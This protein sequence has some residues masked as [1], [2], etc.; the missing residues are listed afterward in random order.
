MGPISLGR[1]PQVPKPL[2]DSLQNFNYQPFS[3]EVAVNPRFLVTS[4]IQKKIGFVLIQ[5]SIYFATLIEYTP[6]LG[7][8]D[9]RSGRRVL[10]PLNR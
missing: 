5:A 2:Y 4:H 7:T 6:I 10:L 1:N 9:S 3:Y 8:D